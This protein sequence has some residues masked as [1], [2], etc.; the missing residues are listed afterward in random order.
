VNVLVKSY[1]SAS[2]EKKGILKNKLLLLGNLL[3]ILQEDPY[4]WFESDELDKNINEKEIEALI[5]ER[6]E[7]KMNK[8]FEKADVIR[9]ELMSKG[10][11]LM[12]SSSGTS[13]KLKT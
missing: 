7:A 9:A 13:W 6:N 10:I 4:S 2:K 12:D 5:V 1:L 3:G 11:E 8:D